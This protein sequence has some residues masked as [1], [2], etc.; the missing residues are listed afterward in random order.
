MKQSSK[1]IDVNLDFW[2][3]VRITFNFKKFACS[4]LHNNSLYIHF[5]IQLCH[6]YGENYRSMVFEN[7]NLRGIFEIRR[8]GNGERKRLH[9][10]KLHSL[11][12]SPKI[13][14]VIV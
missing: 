13:V 7:K 12:R 3:Y 1:F 11:Y 5:N 9:N 2:N 14:R 10:E 4:Q 6:Y 8:D